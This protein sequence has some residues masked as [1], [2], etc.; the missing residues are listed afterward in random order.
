MLNLPRFCHGAGLDDST[1]GVDENRMKGAR[2]N[3]PLNKLK[4]A[5]PS[6]LRVA[7]RGEQEAAIF[8]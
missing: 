5:V 8:K 2:R 4:A 6:S 3:C 7:C 1:G